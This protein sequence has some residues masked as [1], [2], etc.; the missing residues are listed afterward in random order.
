[1]T[2]EG[3]DPTPEELVDQLARHHGKSAA[4]YDRVLRRVIKDAEALG[5]DHQLAVSQ[6][7][8]EQAGLPTAQAQTAAQTWDAH[9][10]LITV[11][12]FLRIEDKLFSYREQ[13]DYVMWE[14]HFRRDPASWERYLSH[15]VH[16]CVGGMASQ[17]EQY[18]YFRRK[19]F[20]V[21][22]EDRHNSRLCRATHDTGLSDGL[23]VRCFHG[24]VRREA[25]THSMLAF[26]ALGPD[27]LLNTRY[28]DTRPLGK[29]QCRCH[30]HPLNETHPEYHIGFLPPYDD[31]GFTA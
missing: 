7:I 17:P 3:R 6:F 23:K 1:M 15:T 24:V 28:T 22:P 29:C 25:P 4:K 8:A 10:D 18:A 2:V 27:A 9:R 16:K 14:M 19:L 5:R 11:E 20:V 31:R 13:V 30:R 12:M 21:T 26:E